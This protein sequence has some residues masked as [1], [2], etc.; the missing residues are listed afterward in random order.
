ML[1]C[2]GVEPATV[3]GLLRARATT[4]PEHDALLVHGGATLT[5]AGWERRAAALAH[6]LVAHGVKPG[7]R[8][9]LYFDNERWTDYGVCYIAVMAA[10]AIAVPLSPR[11][12]AAEIRRIVDHCGAALAVSHRA[13]PAPETGAAAAG[14][15]ELEAGGDTS[16]I[17]L[18]EADGLAEIIYT[19]GTTAAPRG[20]AC[21]HR[22]LMAHDLPPDAGRAA[23][24][25][26]AFPVGTNAGQ[27]CARMPLRRTTTAVVLAS[28]D[29]QQLGGA[30]AMHGIRRLQLVPSMARL[31]VD[32]DAMQ[33]HDVSSVERV[34]LSSAPAPPA[35]WARLAEAFPGASL[36]N[37]YALTEAGGARTLTRFDPSRPAC[38]GRPVGETEL[39]IVDE[40]GADVRPGEPGEVWLRRRGAPPRTYYRDPVAAEA[41]FHGDWVRSGDVGYIDADGCLNLVDRVKDLII[42][43][44][45]NVSSV[46]VEGVLAAHPAVA[47]VAVFGV[48]HEVLGQDVAAAVVLRE[49]IDVRTLQSFVRERLGEHKVPHQVHVVDALPRNDSG[50]VIKRELRERFHAREQ[51]APVPPRN[52]AETAI[53]AIWAEVLGVEPFGVED[54]F[55]S[56]GGQSLAAT[57]VAARVRDAFAVDLPPTAVFE[58]PTVAEL[59]SAVELLRGAGVR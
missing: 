11:F 6:G 47:E 21:T 18:S 51:P 46:E 15:A 33:R 31:A 44:G 45:L 2:S 20:V 48:A 40:S 55:F 34:I 35:L 37:A 49:P 42:T 27:E 23:A 57:Q 8:V 52:P 14:V 28:F 30:I 1:A 4:D 38:V 53:A 24:F 16:P 56:L 17:D 19:S 22:N 13:L 39:R 5:Y 36:W 41:V 3:P 29:P 10:G 59:A 12:S 7:D 32:S 50:K 58:H 9:V 25:L 54:D 26:H 43:G